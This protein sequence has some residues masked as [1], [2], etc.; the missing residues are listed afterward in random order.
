MP[1]WLETPSQTAGIQHNTT[2]GCARLRRKGKVA[3]LGLEGHFGLG[4]ARQPRTVLHAQPSQQLQQGGVFFF[5]AKVGTESFSLKFCARPT[6]FLT[7]LHSLL[8]PFPFPS[9]WSSSWSSG[10][11]PGLYLFLPDAVDAKICF[12]LTE[13][14]KQ[15]FFLLDRNKEAQRCLR[16][17]KKLPDAGLQSEGFFF[18]S[19]S[20]AFS[21]HFL[22]V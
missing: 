2:P 1:G 12:L 3:G 22:K 6:T 11:V 4:S 5:E 8:S 15:A 10:I 18:F 13:I 14:Y 20:L 9:F 17:R 21:W 16:E 19:S 7:K